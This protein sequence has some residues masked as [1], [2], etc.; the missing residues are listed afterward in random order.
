MLEGDQAA[1]AATLLHGPDHL[2]ES[3][4]AGG[5]GGV[6][7]GLR[8]HANTISHARLIALEESFPRTR[9]YLGEAA[10]NEVSRAFIDAGGAQG[11]SL[12]DIGADFAATLDDPLVADLARVE[13]AWLECY[14]A[15][16]GAALALADLAGLDE[17]GLLG[18][19]VR[20]H[21]ATRVI[22]LA[23]D[24]APH[25]D[26]AFAPGTA[27]LLV[28][29]PDAEVRL[30]PVDLADVAALALAQEISPLSNLIAS[31]N[32]DHPNGGAAIAALIAAGA[33]EK[34]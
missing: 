19:R 6:L 7:R 25:V 32:E 13:W 11:R 2:P 16:E 4:F 12:T 1:I 9:D 28:V 15:A 22:R 21:P 24:A 33:L 20:C 31:L 10:F 17:D 34:V 23:S 29:R 26:P 14:H 18:L 5:Q 3:L 27:A 30:L 8:V